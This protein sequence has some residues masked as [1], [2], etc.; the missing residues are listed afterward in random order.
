MIYF[1]GDIHGY[2]WEIK[3]FCK[4]QRLTKDDVLVLLGDVGANYYGDGRDDLMKDALAK[5]APTLLCVHG[6][7]EIRPQLVDGYH[8]AVWN[9]GKVWV[10]DHYPNLLFAQDG[11]IYTLNGLRYIAIGGA[12]SV[13][14]Y[15]PT[16][17]FNPFVSPMVI[18]HGEKRIGI[19]CGSGFPANARN[20][21]VPN[22]RLACLRLD[23]MK[24]FYSKEF[25]DDYD[26]EYTD[27]QVEAFWAQFVN[28]PMDP[29][30][31][32]I[33]DEFLWFTIGTHKKEILR[34]FD[35]H[36][37]KGVAYLRKYENGKDTNTEM[38]ATPK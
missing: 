28:V 16:Y 32:R 8:E 26:T 37:S 14:K 34:W 38:E 7:H 24:E 19:D 20:Y 9:G 10:Q 18:Y 35:R 5:V 27:E 30:L 31:Q 2:P 11:E 12:Y 13:D 15:T 36:H 29:E 21:G 17:D 6:N 3:K 25:L 22:G 1:S 33:E 4:R 23:D